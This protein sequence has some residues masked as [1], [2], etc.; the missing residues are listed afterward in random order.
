MIGDS[1]SI[2][3]QLFTDN[4]QASWRFMLNSVNSCLSL[5]VYESITVKLVIQQQKKTILCISDL[6][7]PLKIITINLNLV[8]KDVFGMFEMSL[9]NH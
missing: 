5:Y 1:K 2:T 7:D 8:R 9:R 4:S 6:Y 3:N